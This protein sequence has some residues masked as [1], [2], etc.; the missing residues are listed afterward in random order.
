[1]SMMRSQFQRHLFGFIYDLIMNAWRE[2]PLQYTQLFNVDKSDAAFEEL[3]TVAGMGLFVKQ[4]EGIEAAQDRFFDGYPKRFQHEDYAL[5]IGFSH[6]FLR[7]IKT[8]VARERST[9]MG[10]SSRSTQ[11]EVIAQMLNLA[12]DSATLGPDGVAL[13]STAHP[14]IRGGTQSNI[15][16]PVSLV[17]VTGFRLM[18]TKFR[19]FFDDTGVRRINLDAAWWVV[20]AEEEWT[21]KEVTKSIGRPDTAN[22]ADNV[23]RGAAEVF[24]YDYLTDVNNHFLLAPKG[25]HKL[26]VFNR[27]T[28][29][30]SEFEDEKP[31]IMWVR[32]RYSQSFGWPHWMGVVGS[33][34]A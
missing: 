32:G 22:R 24:V 27:E 30:V 16:S 18:L 20:P 34:P 7:D 5:S 21:A 10:R 6:Q 1:M 13:C 9:D 17:S 3:R 19:R 26:Q 29:S 12:F 31:M 33:N 2:K 11:E 28:F 8:R 25:Q 23:T 14:N 4:P 15:I